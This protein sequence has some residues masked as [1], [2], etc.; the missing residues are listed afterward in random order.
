[1]LPNYHVLQQNNMA[2]TIRKEVHQRNLSAKLS[3]NQNSRFIEL[4]SWHFSLSGAEQPK[5]D[6]KFKYLNNFKRGPLK[7]NSCEVNDS[8]EELM[9]DCRW[10]DP[11]NM[12][13]SEFGI[14][15][16]FERRSFEIYK[17]NSTHIDFQTLEQISNSV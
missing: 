7:R 5:I 15:L 2:I 13:K 1:M 6:I 17:N 10:T 11:N 14:E 3:L 12:V 16:L 4:K 9:T 8:G